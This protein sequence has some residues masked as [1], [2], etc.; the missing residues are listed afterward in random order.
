MPWVSPPFFAKRFPEHYARDAIIYFLTVMVRAERRPSL[1]PGPHESFGLYGG[2]M[3]G[4]CVFDCCEYNV[5]VI[6]VPAIIAGINREFLDLDEQVIDFQ[7]YYSYEIK[8]IRTIDLREVRQRTLIDLTVRPC[9]A[10]TGS[11]RG[12]RDAADRA[13]TYTGRETRRAPDSSGSA[14]HKPS[15]TAETTRTAADR[16][17]GRQPGGRGDPPWTNS[18]CAR[19]L[20]SGAFG[21]IRHLM[22]R[23]TGGASEE[24]WR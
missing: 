3:T 13:R 10:P 2:T 22:G 21:P 14:C 18:R 6:G 16:F 9:P 5:E 1:G 4:I 8:L 11:P 24:A 20:H 12:H 23:R 17:P 15:R 19:A 7:R